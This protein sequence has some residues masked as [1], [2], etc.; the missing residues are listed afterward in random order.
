MGPNEKWTKVQNFG[1]IFL[2][3]PRAIMYTSQI[4]GR[5]K[6]RGQDVKW[7]KVQIFKPQY[8]REMG[9]DSP[10]SKKHFSQSP[11]WVNVKSGP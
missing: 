10:H 3:A 1:P 8:L 9:A 2:R 4:V 6:Q 5:A 7:T 11:Q